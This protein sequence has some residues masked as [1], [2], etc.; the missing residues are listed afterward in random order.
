MKILLIGLG[1]VGS[2]LAKK[3]G[4]AID[5]QLFVS[6]RNK[7]E[8]QD[9]CM[10]NDLVFKDSITNYSDFD[11][12]LICVKDDAIIDIAESIPEEAPV[13]YTSGALE[14][15]RIKRKNKGVFYP[16]QTFQK[17]KAI[18]FENIPFFIE[19]D[20][21]HLEST[22]FKLAERLSRNVTIAN[23]EYRKKIHVA[24]VFANNFTNFMLTQA[25]DFL[26][27]ENIPFS[28]LLPLLEK[29]IENVKEDHPKHF[30]TGPALR[31]DSDTIM[32]HKALL[33]NKQREIYSFL[34]EEI[35][36]YYEKL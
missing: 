32:H 24:A 26:A 12:V 22:L 17:S 6:S 19:A 14:L 33:D 23:S 10:Q 18:R 35:K 15:D 2:H 30:Q 3:I 8:A 1:N 28:H 9:F 13:A 34:S 36:N 11:L 20:H 25:A 5:I 31:D 4:S 27:G 21:Q 16:L 29:T 7:K